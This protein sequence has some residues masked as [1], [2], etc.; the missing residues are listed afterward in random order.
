M[1]DDR[2]HN[3]SAEWIKREEQKYADTEC[4]SWEDISQDELQ[5][6]LKKASNWKSPGADAVPNFWLK[7][8]TALHQHLLNAYKQAIEHP[9]NL[10]DWFTTAQTYLL[11][12]TKTQRTPKT[13]DQ[14]PVYQH[15]TRCP[16]TLNSLAD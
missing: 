16:E 12:R 3:H 15:P 13:I 6:V 9:E 14:L 5:T 10:L 8:L 4:H 7:Q 1:E 2:E 11:P